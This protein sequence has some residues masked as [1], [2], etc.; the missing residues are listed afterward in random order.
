[1]VIMKIID[2]IIKVI[3]K[4]N[5]NDNEINRNDNDDENNHKCDNNNKRVM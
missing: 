4:G 3:M 2:N 5:D 1:M